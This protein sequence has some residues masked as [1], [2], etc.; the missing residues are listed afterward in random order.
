M[1]LISFGTRPEYIKIKPLLKV[2][3]NHIPYKLLF[4]GQ[5]VDL[6]S[7]LQEDLRKL[8]VINGS[9]RLDSIVASVM[10]NDEIF[11][12]VDAVL[13]Q[14]DTTSVLAVALAAFH[15]KIK[16]IHL[17][18]GLRT[19]NKDHPYPEEFNR[20]VVSCMA[21][22]NLCPTQESVS[23]LQ[24]EQA[25]GQ[26]H[27]VG[28]TVLDNLTHIRPEYKNH[29]VVTMHRRENH[30]LLPQWFSEIDKL[31]QENPELEFI[32]PIHPN[33]N[34]QKHRHL[35][36]YV[37]VVEPMAYDDFLQLLS[38]CFLVITD[39]G[40]LQ[41]E[42]SFFMKKCI[43][44][45]EKTERVEGMGIFSFMTGPKDLNS[46]FYLLKEDHIP[47]GKCPYGDGYSAER[48][49]DILLKEL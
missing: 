44:C 18:A 48:I 33:P 6:L 45:R 43:V 4:T 28:N 47:A 11:E 39:S 36:K 9:N 30:L 46:L 15:R 7:S 23:N 19:Y 10:N 25:P 38:T 41:E 16:V 31:A 3:K 1:I 2:F 34:V 8:K 37:N 24:K 40:G 21:D 32:L 22:I 49:R 17:E 27:L 14:G 12:D 13:V 26:M 42:S 20:R 35:L 29:V 5:H